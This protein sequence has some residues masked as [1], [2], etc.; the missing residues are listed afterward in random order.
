M[1]CEQFAGLAP[2]AQEFLEAH[3]LPPRICPTC[4]QPSFTCT[5]ESVA[6]YETGWGGEDALYRHY[7]K[8]DQYADEFLQ[9]VEFSSGPVHFLGLRLQDGTELTWTPEDMEEWL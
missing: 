7:L 2:I 1:R 8:E 9:T 6:T 5:K 3:R 4:G